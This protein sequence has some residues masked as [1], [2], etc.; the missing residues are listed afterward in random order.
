MEKEKKIEDFGIAIKLM[1]QTQRER[2]IIKARKSKR[3]RYS[4]DEI[5]EIFQSIERILEE[6][7]KELGIEPSFDFG[8][9]VHCNKTLRE[10]ARN[11]IEP[12]VVTV[13]TE[14]HSFGKGVKGFETKNRP[15]RNCEPAAF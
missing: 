7:G 10:I 4:T 5:K 11:Y 8:G 13:F 2:D 12:S 15:H 1:V 14:S 3:R 6:C 9:T